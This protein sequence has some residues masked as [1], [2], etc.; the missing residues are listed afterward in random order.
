MIKALKLFGWLSF[1]LFV[2]LIIGIIC[3]LVYLGLE[4]NGFQM[5]IVIESCVR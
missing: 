4:I 5:G 1:Y 2:F 3:R